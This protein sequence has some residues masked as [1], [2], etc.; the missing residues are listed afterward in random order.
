MIANHI[1]LSA[2]IGRLFTFEHGNIPNPKAL[3]GITLLTIVMTSMTTDRSALHA[4]LTNPSQLEA[5]R[6][7]LLPAEQPDMLK[8]RHI[9]ALAV[10][11]ILHRN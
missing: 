8:L 6:Q 7:M 5:D 9:A 3:A 10:E 4:L 2:E 1:E 11:N